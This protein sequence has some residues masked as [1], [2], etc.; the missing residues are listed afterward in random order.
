MAEISYGPFSWAFYSRAPGHRTIV[1]TRMPYHYSSFE[2]TL[3]KR[4]RM[5]RW[6]VCTVQGEL[7]MKGSENSRPAARYKSDRALFLLL[8]SAAYLSTRKVRVSSLD[9][10]TRRRLSNLDPG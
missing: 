2:A 6:C 10:A 3:K 7:V 1:A 9:Q 5:W 8:L 4:G